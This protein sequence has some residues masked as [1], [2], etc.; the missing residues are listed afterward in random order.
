M[1][2]GKLAASVGD[3]DR[4]RFFS[5]VL[6][7][8]WKVMPGE[9]LYRRGLAV[10][11]RFGYSFYDSLIIAAAV[12]AGCRQLYSEDLQDQQRIDGLVIVNPFSN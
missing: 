7:P 11:E 12:A 9:S 4:D 1:L 10:K 3:R 2:T 5:T 6:L 8:L